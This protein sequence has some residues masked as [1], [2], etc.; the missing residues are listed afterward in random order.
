MEQKETKEILKSVAN[1]F[2]KLG[3]KNTL[4]GEVQ[5]DNYTLKQRKWGNAKIYMISNGAEPVIEFHAYMDTGKINATVKN[6]DEVISLKT[7]L[8]RKEIMIGLDENLKPNKTTT[9]NRMKIK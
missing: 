5:L 7:F 3:D 2:N 6:D 9:A 8:G 4:L 1:V